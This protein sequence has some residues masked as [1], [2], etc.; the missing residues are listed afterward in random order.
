[1]ALGGLWYNKVKVLLDTNMLLVPYQFRVDIFSQLENLL[2]Q[3]KN[4][5]VSS[6]TIEEIEKLTK[7]GKGKAKVAA[8][9]AQQ[10]LEHYPIK[11]LN[12]TMEA[13]EFIL[14]LVRDNPG[15]WVIATN[16]KEL[17]D[18][19]RALGGRVICLRGRKKLSII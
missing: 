6:K 10:L 18:K 12:T 19:I 15:E 7:Y 13:D 4:Y 17:K 14:T 3:V 2:P 9:I 5:F 11:V 1:M 8:R 16:D